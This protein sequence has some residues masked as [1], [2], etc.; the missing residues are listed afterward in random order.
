ME[1]ILNRIESFGRSA[2]EIWVDGGWAMA[3]I[4]LTAFVMFGIGLHLFRRLGRTLQCVPESTWRRW[5]REPAE[6]RGRLGEL[7]SY[8]TGSHSITHNQSVFEEL[9]TS[10]I[11]PFERDLRVMKVCVSAAPL[12]GLLGTVTGMLTT[13]TALASGSGGEQTMDQ[14]AGGISEALVTTETGLVI[15]LPGLFFRYLLSRRIERYKVFLAQLESACSQAIFRE[16][17]ARMPAPVVE[18][19]TVPSVESGAE[20]Q[21]VAV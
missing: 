3:A 9:H 17:R 18:T 13:F 21:E 8:A 10:E 11:S 6:R 4:G 20:L 1:A 19:P 12:L 14:I 7:I 5:V 15:A 2:V 16:L